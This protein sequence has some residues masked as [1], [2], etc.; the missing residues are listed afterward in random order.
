MKPLALALALIRNFAS[1][2]LTR[3][4]ALRLAAALP[5]PFPIVAPVLP[6][7]RRRP[8]RPSRPNQE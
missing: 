8:S 5:V 6:A 3:G 4:P 2:Q 1:Y 7:R